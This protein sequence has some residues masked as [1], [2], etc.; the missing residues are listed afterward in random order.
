MVVVIYCMHIIIK[1]NADYILL[2]PC[3]TLALE[4]NLFNQV[5]V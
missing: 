1:E 5:T 2:Q 4:C 3:L